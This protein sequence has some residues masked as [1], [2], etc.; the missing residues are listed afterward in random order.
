MLCLNGAAA[1]AIEGD[2]AALEPLCVDG[3]IL[4]YRGIEIELGFQAFVGIP[5]LELA[6]FLGRRK[7]GLY[8][9]VTGFH[10]LRG[11]LAAAVDVEEDIKDPVARR[12]VWLATAG[13]GSPLRLGSR[14]INGCRHAVECVIADIRHPH[15]DLDASERG[16]A[17]KGI[18]LY[19]RN[20]LGQVYGFQFLAALK[21]ALAQS[22][23]TLWDVNAHE[24]GA[25]SECSFADVRHA[26][27]NLDARQLLVAKAFEPGFLEFVRESVR[28]RESPTPDTRHRG[29]DSR[30]RRSRQESSGLRLDDGIS[31]VAAIVCSVLR[32]HDNCRAGAIRESIL[33]DTRDARWNR[34]TL[35]ADAKG[36]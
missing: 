11:H 8:R 33:T 20:A 2:N 19:A 1:A 14:V 25:A 28:L 21:G 15:R 29:R 16:A 36:E 13:Y 18:V 12:L 31:P 27:G 26:V 35:E 7:I 9:L 23:H 32:C 4:G 3:R 34:D 22:C 6:P 24:L 5:A 30:V 17:G 10:V